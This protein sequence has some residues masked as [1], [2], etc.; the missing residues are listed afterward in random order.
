MLASQIPSKVPLPFANSGTKNAI[1]TA[2]Q[3]GIT[4]GAASLTD[5]FPPLTFTP[6]NA[7]GVPPA[8]ADFNGIFNLITSVQQWQSAGGI[9]KYD[10]TFSTAI[11]GY[12][13]GA[14]L[15]STSNDTEWLNTSDNNTTDPDNAGTAA[16]WVSLVAYGICAVSGLT[17]ANVTLTPAQYGKRIITLAGTLTGNVQIIFPTAT[18]MWEV[19]NNTTGAF[20]VTCKTAAG[21]GMIVAQ[22]DAVLLLGDG[23]NIVSG[24][25]SKIGADARYA[26]LAASNAWTASQ[27]ITLT[28]NNPPLLGLYRNDSTPTVA[29]FLG[30]IQ[31]IGNNAALTQTLFAEILGRIITTTAGNES[32]EITFRRFLNGVFAEVFN[33]RAGL[34]ANGLSDP[35]AGAGNFTALQINGS[36][37]VAGGIAVSNFTGANQSLVANGYQKIPGG[38]I[39][40][41]GTTGSISAGSTSTITLPIAFPTAFVSVNPTETSNGSG[42]A[43]ANNNAVVASLSTF[44]LSNRSTV[45][46][47]F[48][49][50]AVGY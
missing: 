18:H 4:A 15:M 39:L 40:Q 12:P 26:Q 22:T 34:Y 11:G 30:S 20:S 6:L 9:F 32:G 1:P 31:F 35:G 48:M 41:W 19:V 23:T 17:N 50:L 38:L 13:K 27:Q 24:A 45:P 36:A 16:N 2:S 49:W 42:A 5:G 10:P 37:V 44:S 29:D 25:L 8:G 43:E 3:I 33:M 14:I 28:G 47:T 46:Q 7:G 21:T